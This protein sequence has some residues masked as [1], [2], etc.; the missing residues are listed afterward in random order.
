[1]LLNT[2]VATQV[3]ELIGG[4]VHHSTDTASDEDDAKVM[5]R[6]RSMS[7]MLNNGNVLEVC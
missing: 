1:M 5:R 3:H 7:L 2:R 6:L 4:A